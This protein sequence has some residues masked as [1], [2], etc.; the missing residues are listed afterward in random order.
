MAAILNRFSSLLERVD[1]PVTGLL[2]TNRN[3]RVLADDLIA[4]EVV[5]FGLRKV[6][7]AD[8]TVAFRAFG[9]TATPIVMLIDAYGRVR[10]FGPLEADPA[11][12]DAEVSR[13]R[14]I[15]SGLRGAQ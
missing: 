7:P 13:I 8:L 6:E 11:A 15:V 12:A 14:G 5:S 9:I 10:Y 3:D 2:L 4:T 1:V